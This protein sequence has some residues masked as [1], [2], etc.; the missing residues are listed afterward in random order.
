[1]RYYFL[2]IAT[3]L[4]CFSTSMLAQRQQLTPEQR[5]QRLKDTLALSEKQ[6]AS[7]LKIFQEA[8]GERKAIFESNA[9]DRQAMMQAMRSLAEKTDG[10]IEA[11][12]TSDQK[13]KYE[14]LK[15]QRQER[16]GGMRRKS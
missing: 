3:L 10:K 11:L 14:E 7:V 9:G 16:A 13:A 6:E 2:F 15:K 5:T 4:V 1:M 8:D 12:L